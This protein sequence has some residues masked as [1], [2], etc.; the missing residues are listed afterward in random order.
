MSCLPLSVQPNAKKRSSPSECAISS[1]NTGLLKN[2]S[3][4]SLF[5][6]L[7][8]LT[9]LEI[10]KRFQKFLFPQGLPF[11]GVK[12]ETTKLAY[13]IE[14]KWSNTPQKYP[15]VSRTGLEPVTYSLRGNCST[16]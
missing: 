12:F 3:S 8:F 9:F 13:C 10:K 15:M 6:T 14:P 7:C 16:N 1:N 2:T 11:D 4:V 5:C